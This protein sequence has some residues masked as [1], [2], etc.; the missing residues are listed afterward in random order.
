M[1]RL[2]HNHQDIQLKE[3]SNCIFTEQIASRIIGHGQEEDFG[4]LVVSGSARFLYVHVERLVQR[5]GYHPAP[6]QVGERAVHL[7]AWR[8]ADDLISWTNKK[9]QQQVYYL[10]AAHTGYNS[11][12]FAP[13]VLGKHLSQ[14]SLSGVRIDV[15]GVVVSQR[16]GHIGRSAV[17]VFVPVELHD[18]VC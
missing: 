10:V 13:S 7:K 15:I 11:L 5:D 9:A 2:I 18:S 14:P 1:V 3:T 12:R 4:I 16:L 6:H 17:Q 8:K